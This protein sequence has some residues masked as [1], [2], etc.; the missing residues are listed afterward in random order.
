MGSAGSLASLLLWG[1]P[2]V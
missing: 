1:A 2:A